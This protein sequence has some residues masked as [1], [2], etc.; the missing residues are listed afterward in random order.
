MEN[1]AA[2]EVEQAPETDAPQLTGD[3]NVANNALHLLARVDIKG[4]EVPAFNQ[5]VLMLQ[6]I[7]DGRKVLRAAPAAKKR[8]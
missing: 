2:K 4:A 8:K 7:R 5:A 6:E 3:R 1:G